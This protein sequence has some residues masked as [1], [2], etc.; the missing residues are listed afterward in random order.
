MKDTNDAISVIWKDLKNANLNI[1]GQIYKITRAINSRKEDIVINSLP[2]AGDSLQR[3]FIN[4]NAYV[5][6][7]VVTIDGQND[8]SLP[9][10][11]RLKA[12]TTAIISVLEDVSA[13]DHYYFVASQQTLREELL[14]QHYSNI[15]L[16]FYFINN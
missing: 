16:E 7:L 4:V 2:M 5:N 10:T 14:N 12:L 15:R 6:N 8:S 11:A 3:C 13:A 9:D 1:T